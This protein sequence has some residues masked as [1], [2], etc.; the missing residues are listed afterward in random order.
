MVSITVGTCDV[1]TWHPFNV[2][3]FQG[4]TARDEAP[5]PQGRTLPNGLS[6]DY[7][8]DTRLPGEAQQQLQVCSHTVLCTHAHHMII[9]VDVLIFFIVPTTGQ[10]N[11]SARL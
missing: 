3:P 8:V 11:D 4:G 6:I 10:P 5:A 7:D 9:I 1:F 2:T